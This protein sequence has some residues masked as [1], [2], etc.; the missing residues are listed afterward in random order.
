MARIV[1][2]GPL[3]KLVAAAQ[4]LEHGGKGDVDIRTT[5]EVG[6]LAYA[7]RR[8]GGAIRVREERI[9]ARNRDM[10]LVLDNV[11]Q[12]FVTLDATGAMSQ[13]RS[14]YQR[15]VRGGGRGDEA[16]GLPGP[17]RR[18]RGPAVPDRV[19]AIGEDV[20]PLSLCLDQLPKLVKTDG[21]AYELAY[22]PIL[23]DDRLA[24]LI[25]VITDITSRIERERA[26]Q[27]QWEMMSVF[28]R[29]LS[30]R[31]ALDDFFAETSKLVRT[32]M[33][34]PGGDDADLRVDPDRQRKHRP[35]G[36]LRWQRSAIS[37]R[38]SLPRHRAG[39]K[40][41]LR[42]TGTPSE[43]CWGAAAAMH[44]QLTRLDRAGP[45]C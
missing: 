44:A 32:I 15:V 4:E 39:P 40:R 2:V 27:A 41:C 8:M 18:I 28:C 42:P 35:S 10:R 3:G 25:V 7:F 14:R 30:D 21:R 11:G 12:G 37:W 13:E 20:L 16:V 22:R 29:A 38:R 26:E 5:D 9:G 36:I 43:S 1:V 6:Q 34:A 19:D 45:S 33:D 17:R 31:A 23:E 24:K